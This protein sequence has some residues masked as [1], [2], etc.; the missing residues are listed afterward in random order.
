MPSEK[1]AVMAVTAGFSSLAKSSRMRSSTCSTEPICVKL[2]RP[3]SA[4]RVIRNEFGAE[5]IPTMNT[6]ERP[7][8]DPMVSN[9]CCSLPIAP[10]VRNTT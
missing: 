4:A 9:S 5:P 2:P 1:R 6:R 8:S 7:R 3:S 10:S